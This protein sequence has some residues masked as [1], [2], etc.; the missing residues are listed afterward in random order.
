MNYLDEQ[1]K[2]VAASEP[3][4]IMSP[5]RIRAF[6]EGVAVADSV[7]A[8][9]LRGGGPPVYYFPPEDMRRD[10]MAFVGGGDLDPRG[11]KLTAEI[12]VGDRVIEDAAWEY[13]EPTEGF[14][15]LK[16]MVSL[17]WNAMDAWFEEEEEV[18]VHARD[19][20][21]R[22]DTVK[23]GRRIEV[24]LAGERVADTTGAILLIEP[25]HPMRYYIPKMDVR[26]EL[27]RPS[28]RVSR[29]PYKGEANYY[30]LEVQGTLV[31]DGAWSYK[32]PTPES[33]KVAGL[34]CFFNERVDAIVVDG[35]DLGKPTTRWGG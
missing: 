20:F 15:F 27:L 12:K 16:G 18:F 4:W 9:L 11:R 17:R 32:Y 35:E 30:S 33:S 22:I 26:M 6:V 1:N 19:P 10:L 13:T 3:R 23:S 31:E 25:G 5:K 8:Y 2:L 14:S 24:M 28:Q 7:R 34:I 29:C 21:K